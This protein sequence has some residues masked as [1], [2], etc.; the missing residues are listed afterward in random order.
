MKKMQTVEMGNK[1]IERFIIFIFILTTS[2][3]LYIHIINKILK[4]FLH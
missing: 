1:I 2:F 4:L 3:S